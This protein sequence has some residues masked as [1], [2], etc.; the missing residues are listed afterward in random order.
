MAFLG[1]SLDSD[2]AA[3]DAMVSSQQIPWPQLC[4]GRG[5]ESELVQRYS[6]RGTPT[7]VLIDAEGRIIGKLRSA[8]QLPERLA[9]LGL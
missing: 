5:F 8:E 9:E 4:D 3:L 2:L 1:V 7:L 6:V